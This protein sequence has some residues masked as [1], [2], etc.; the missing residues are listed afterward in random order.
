VS[1]PTEESASLRRQA[2]GGAGSGGSGSGQYEV[3]LSESSRG[4][5]PMKTAVFTVAVT[6]P[7]GNAWQ[8]ERRLQDFEELS[9]A[10]AADAGSA[11]LRAAAALL[12]PRRRTGAGRVLGAVA[13][14]RAGHA[15][16]PLPRAGKLSKDEE[17]AARLAA[18]QHMLERA[19][20]VTVQVPSQKCPYAVGPPSSCRMRLLPL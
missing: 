16:A 17:Q 19:L 3:A 7:R 12:P 18:L 6:G 1:A 14:A 5:G 8:V 15:P 9:E 10:L 13:S 20:Q 4:S 2:N 11:P